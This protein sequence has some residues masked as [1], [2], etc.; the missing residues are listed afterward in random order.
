MFG[1]CIC[2]NELLRTVPPLH[3]YVPSSH[4]IGSTTTRKHLQDPHGDQ[5]D[6]CVECIGQ[7]AMI[8]A[9]SGNCNSSPLYT[10][11]DTTG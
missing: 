4:G 6:G 11:E 10:R 1:L 2:S 8:S 3:L 7:S 5:R 9:C